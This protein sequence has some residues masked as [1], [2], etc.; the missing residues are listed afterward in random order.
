M[1]DRKLTVR[2]RIMGVLL[3]DA[4]RRA[5]RTKAECADALGVSADTIEAYEQGR[6]PISLPELEVLGY[7]VGT[8]IH[9]FT[10]PDPELSS[11]DG[12][13]PGL[14]AVLA[15]RHRIVGALLRQ[16]RLE[17]GV[18]E[19]G[20][21]GVLHCSPRRLSEYEGGKRPI[22]FSELE[23]AAAHLSLPLEWFVDGRRGTVS[24]WHRQKEID[25]G[26]HRLPDDVQEFV[27]EEMNK[28]C[29]DVAMMLSRLPVNELRALAQGLLEIADRHCPSE[30]R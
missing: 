2:D 29:L 13:H 12:A 6:A 10:D 21:A 5:R 15:L 14:L 17:A 28:G 16:A 30:G 11:G 9:C 7:V 4:R 22:P 27:S 18:T 25:R 3:R 1:F 20:L 24:T 8:P 26:F 19:E 23:L